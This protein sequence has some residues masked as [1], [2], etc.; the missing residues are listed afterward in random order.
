MPRRK[1]SGSDD[2]RGSFE[3]EMA[4]VKRLPPGPAVVPP[5]A[6]EPKHR[7]PAPPLAEARRVAF[8]IQVTGER[9]AGRAPGIDRRMLA[10]LRSGDFPAESRV[11]LHG[12]DASAARRAVRG[13]IEAAWRQ[14]LRCVLVVHGRGAHSEDGPVL[15]QALL[16]W[17]GEAPVGKRVMAFASAAP[18]EG[19]PGA[20]RVLLRRRRA[21]R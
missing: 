11:D 12:L 8:E 21:R 6:S 14:G 17:L 19:G 18:G 15:K 4:G 16:D 2:G 7:G 10:R 3:R 20:T 5:A 13:C 1:S 9:V